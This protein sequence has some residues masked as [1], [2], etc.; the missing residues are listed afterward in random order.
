MHGQKKSPLTKF[1]QR[2]CKSLN[3]GGFKTLYKKMSHYF[4]KPVC[5]QAGMT[6][7]PGLLNSHKKQPM[8]FKKNIP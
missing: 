7:P 5:R 6:A 4:Y 1:G 3:L 2:A 8:C